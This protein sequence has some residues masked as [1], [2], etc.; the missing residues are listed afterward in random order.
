MAGC[1][2]FGLMLDEDIS[3]LLNHVKDK[4]NTSIPI[5]SLPVYRHNISST[6]LDTARQMFLYLGSCQK[7]KIIDKNKNF[8]QFFKDLFTKSPRIILQNIANIQQFTVGDKMKKIEHFVASK[9]MEKLFPLLHLHYT[10][11]DMALATGNMIEN[12]LVTCVYENKTTNCENTINKV[13]TI[14]NIQF[15]LKI[16]IKTMA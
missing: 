12:D 6:L 16:I 9:L 14:G 8:E 3:Y 2:G 4:S 7:T 5:H 15:Q 11:I 1:D 13:I 10:A